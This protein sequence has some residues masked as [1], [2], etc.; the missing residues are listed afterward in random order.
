MDALRRVKSNTVEKR[1]LAE[2]GNPA[3]HLVFY[4]LNARGE[5]TGLSMYSSF[6]GHAF[7]YSVCTENDPETLPAEGLLGEAPVEP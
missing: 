4:I 1:L 2:G 6:R 7:K 3:F 5:H